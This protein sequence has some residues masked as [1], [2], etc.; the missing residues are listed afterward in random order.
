MNLTNEK[1]KEQNRCYYC[2]KEL[3]KGKH[4]VYT[5]KEKYINLKP[6]AVR[7]LYLEGKS[8]KEITMSD[9]KE[10]ITPS[11]TPKNPNVGLGDAQKK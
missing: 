5:C 1:L 9:K 4:S 3:G 11:N 2:T 7:K 10:S 6:D 8:F